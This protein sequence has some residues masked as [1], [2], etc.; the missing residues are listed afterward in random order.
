MSKINP[1]LNILFA[2]YPDKWEMYKLFF[3]ESPIALTVV[4]EDGTISYANKKFAELTGYK[5]HEIIGEHFTKFVAEQDRERMNEYHIKRVRGEEA[6]QEYEYKCLRKDGKIRVVRIKVIKLPE[7]RTLSCKI[8]VTE[9]KEVEELFKRVVESTILA[10]FIYQDDHFVYVN[11]AVEKLTGY[12]KEEL[13]KMKFWELVHEKYKE[14]VKERGRKRQKGEEIE[15]SIYEIPYYTKDG[16]LKWALCSLTNIMYKGK[17]AALATAM[18]ITDKKVAE[19]EIRESRRKFEFLYQNSPSLNIIIGF[20]GRIIDINDSFLKLTGYKK[21]EVIGKKVLSFVADYHKEKV[22]KQLEQDFKGI[23]TPSIEVDIKGKKQMH[24]ILFGEGQVIVYEKGEPIGVLLSGIDVTTHKK[25]EK[26]LKESEERFR[27]VADLLPTVI[28]EFNLDGK[29]LYVNKAGFDLFGYT[30]EDLKA[31]INALDLIHPEDRKKAEERIKE[32][33]QGKKLGPIEYRMFKKDGSQ[34]NILVNSSPIYKDGKVVGIRSVL[35]NITELKR[36]EKAL[37]RSEE[38][39]RNL[40][41]KMKD[42][43]YI[44]TIDGKFIDV[45]QAMVELL[46]YDSKEEIY[47]LDIT[48]DFYCNPGDREKIIKEISKKGYVKDYEIEI[49]RKDGKKLIVLETCHERRDE[50]GNVI[51]FEGIIRDITEKKEMERAL[52]ESEEKYR[53]LVE[54]SQ[55]GICVDD[56]NENI[57]FVNEAFAK[58]LGYKK[59][60]LLGKNIFELV[61]EDDR[62]KLEEEVK[63][64]RKGEASKYEI[65]FIAKDGRIKTF[66]VSAIPLYKNGKFVGSLSV[67]LDITERKIA[68]EKLAE[69]QA[70]YKAITESSPSGIFILQGGEFKFV[71]SKFSNSIGYT[72]EELKKMN[73]LE[74]IHREDRYKV[75]EAIKKVMKKEETILPEFRYVTKDGR[76]RWAVGTGVVIEYKG[77]PALLGTITDITEIKEMHE[78]ER[79]FIEDTSHYFFNPIC[80]AK[81]YIELI[82]ERINGEEKNMLEK[83]NQALTRLEKI[84]KNIVTRGEIHE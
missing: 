38:K 41:E 11:P 16:K 14:K 78:K 6:P 2:L 9:K 33:I 22:M 54:M 50:N 3:E 59:E 15:P 62:K 30:V 43:L 79:K 55:E 13:L 36:T 58:L 52:K 31:G 42:A 35:T 53:M 29:I 84:V 37:K 66:I 60:E 65:R 39:Y 75:N 46:G 7:N 27:E 68:E 40:F 63:K 83:A 34:L 32:I 80:V 70:L 8:D 47:K 51:G 17:P 61:H 64:R 77:R 72:L 18:D 44:S 19:E 81:G 57:T 4:E 23:K 69:S 76:V 49:K 24:T 26:A 12:C 20:D 45:N 67:N 28:C 56:E 71:N 25:M 5:L 73:Y 82:R 74:L 1:M 10:V 21:E 48:K